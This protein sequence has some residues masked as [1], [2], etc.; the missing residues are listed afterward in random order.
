MIELFTAPTPNGHKVSIMLEELGVPYEFRDVGLGEGGQH[1]PEYTTLNP[2]GK[3]PTIIDHDND[4]FVVFESGAILIYLAE[5]YGQFLPTEP[6]AR[7]EVL[8]WLMLQMGGLG[9]MMGQANVW[10]RYFE[11][12]VP[13]AISRYQSEVRRLFEVLDARLAG[14]EYI[15]DIYSIADIAMWAWARTYKWSGVSIEG[16]E[17]LHRWIKAIRARPAVDRGIRIPYDIGNLLKESDGDAAQAR[18]VDM[19]RGM[20]NRGD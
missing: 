4:G 2:N 8:Q 13:Q 9:P 16:L 15:V 6:G 19:A 5:K 14:R 3:I 1:D 7:S 12:A 10:F 11:E 17:H 18:F 20:L